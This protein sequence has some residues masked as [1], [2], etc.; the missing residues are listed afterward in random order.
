MPVLGKLVVLPLEV[1]GGDVIE[2]QHGRLANLAEVGAIKLVLYLF[3]ILRQP[4]QRFVQ[5]VLVKLRNSQYLSYGMLFGPA[6]RR[7]S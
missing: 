7:E 6:H 3:L 4:I 1:G 5:I 2:D